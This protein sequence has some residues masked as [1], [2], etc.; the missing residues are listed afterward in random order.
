MSLLII[1][2]ISYIDVDFFVL[3]DFSISF[4]IWMDYFRK[5]H[6]LFFDKFSIKF[7]NVHVN[8]LN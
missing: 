5:E 7:K 3:L 8:I 4:Y 6:I 2:T 1:E